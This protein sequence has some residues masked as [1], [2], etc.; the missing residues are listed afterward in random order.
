MM[1]PSVEKSFGAHVNVPSIG[2]GVDER[3][4]EVA[5]VRQVRRVR[6]EVAVA[7]VGRELVPA[8]VEEVGRRRRPRS[9]G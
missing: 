6:L 2:E 1:S 5:R 4:V 8:H 7:R 9:P 3:R